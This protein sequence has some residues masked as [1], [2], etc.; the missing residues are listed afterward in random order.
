MAISEKDTSVQ[1]NYLYYWPVRAKCS[2][3]CALV[4]LELF[5]SFEIKV[6]L[7]SCLNRQRD[8]VTLA[9]CADLVTYPVVA[10]G[11]SNMAVGFY[12]HCQ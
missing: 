6:H 8:C 4:F 11:S 9:V 1:M 5:C 12:H 3:R 2:M 10:Q 7:E